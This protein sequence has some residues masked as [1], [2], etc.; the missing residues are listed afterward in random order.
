MMLV[1]S[2][3]RDLCRV[4]LCNIVGIYFDGR[5]IARARGKGLVSLHI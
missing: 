1:V 3:S 2:I 4:S 5:M